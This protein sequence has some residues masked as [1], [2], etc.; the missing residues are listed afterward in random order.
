MSV[1]ICHR[2]YGGAYVDVSLDG[3]PFVGFGNGLAVEDGGSG[4]HGCGS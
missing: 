4:R 2:E 3:L 1:L